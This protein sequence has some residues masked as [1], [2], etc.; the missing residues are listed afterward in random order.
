MTRLLPLAV[1][2]L[3]AG[4]TGC[5]SAPKQAGQTAVQTEYRSS[6]SPAAPVT[7]ASYPPRLSAFDTGK[8]CKL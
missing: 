8:D 3:V 1:A 6:T 2:G 7:P 4:L 5:S